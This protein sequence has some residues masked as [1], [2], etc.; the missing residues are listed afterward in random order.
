MAGSG[1]LLALGAADEEEEVV[2]WGSFRWG[3]PMCSKS[4]AMAG[5]I[6]ALETARRARAQAFAQK[7]IDS[8]WVWR[9]RWVGRRFE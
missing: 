1:P 7:P 2:G 6:P 9:G 3:S 8:I 4:Q 5:S